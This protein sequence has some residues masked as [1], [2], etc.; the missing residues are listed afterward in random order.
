MN[1]RFIFTTC[2]PAFL[3]CNNASAN[4]LRT[5]DRVLYQS[6]F[7]LF[8]IG[9]SFE[10][11]IEVCYTENTDTYA[12]KFVEP[13]SIIDQNNSIQT[14]IDNLAATELHRLFQKFFRS[15]PHF[16][17]NSASETNIKVCS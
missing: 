7:L 6:I 4:L 16:L 1:K 17:P 13:F 12:S 14:V 15:Y 3:L 5:R 2:T 10:P 11:K 8:H 9:L